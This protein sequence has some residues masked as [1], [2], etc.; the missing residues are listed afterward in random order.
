MYARMNSTQAASLG[1]HAVNDYLKRS[2]ILA[3]II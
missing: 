1:Y 2:Q 3:G